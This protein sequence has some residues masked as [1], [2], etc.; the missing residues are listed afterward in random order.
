[1]PVSFLTI[2]LFLIIDALVGTISVRSD[3]ND[4]SVPFGEL[5]TSN[6][7]LL[8]LLAINYLLLVLVLV[9]PP[10]LDILRRIGIHTVNAIQL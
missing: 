4:L 2:I 8:L 10:L 3:V 1:M 6:M 5:F 7:G 9:S